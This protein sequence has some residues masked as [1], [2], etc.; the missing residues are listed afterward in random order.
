MEFGARSKNFGIKKLGFGLSC[1]VGQVGVQE[2]KFKNSGFGC[3]GVVAFLRLGSE[4]ENLGCTVAGCARMH[5]R[6]HT[7]TPTGHYL[8][9]KQRDRERE[10]E[11]EMYLCVCI[12][13]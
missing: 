1:L 10:R 7:V 5:E 3:V 2:L 11:R 6:P 8:S 13:K 4:N 9:G 12:N